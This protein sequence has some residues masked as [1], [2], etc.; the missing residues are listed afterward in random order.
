MY[1]TFSRKIKEIPFL[2]SF[3]GDRVIYKPRN[4]SFNEVK[5]VLGWGEKKN[6]TK[7]KNFA[8]KY[9]LPY[10]SLEDGFI[11]SYGLRIKGY[12]P[13]SLIVDPIGIYYD[14]TKPSLLEHLLNEG[15][16][17]KKDLLEAEKALNLI[18][19]HEISKFNYQEK[20]DPSILKGKRA[21]RVLVIDQT[22]NDLSVLLGMATK[23]SFFEMLD[24][25]LKDNPDADIYIKIHPDVLSGKKKGY[26]TDV[27]EG[28]RIYLITKDVNPISLL[29]FFDKIYTVSS[30]MGFEAL[31]LG[32]P[33]V[34]F[35]IPFYAGWGLTEDI[36][37]IPRRKRKLSLI[38]L[39]YFSY[40]KYCRYINPINGKLGTIFDVIN[41]IL[42]QREMEDRI[43]KFNYYCIDFHIA[44]RKFLTPYLKTSKNRVYFVKAK[45]LKRNSNFLEDLSREK[46]IVVVWGNKGKNNLLKVFK[47]NVPI[48]VIEDGFIRSVGLGS[49]F[50]PPMSIVIDKRGIYYNPQEESDLEYILNNYNFSEAEIEKAKEIRKLII[51]NRITKYNLENLKGHETL[52]KIKEFAKDKKIILVPGQVEDDEAV[53]LGGGE[54]K[55]NLELLKKVRMRDQDSFIIY[56]PH[57][58]ILS[59]NRQKEKW[60]KRLREVCD[61]IEEEADILSCIEIADEIHTLTSLSGF[62]AL[63]RGKRVFT[64]GAPFYAGWG[65]TIDELKF[66]RRKRNLTIEELIAGTLLIYPIYYDWKL[67]A[68]ADCET[69]IY[70]IIEEKQNFKSNLKS[71][72]PIFIKKGI[73]YINF[74]KRSIFL[75][76][77]EK[78]FS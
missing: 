63:I 33:V 72:L 5:G 61:Y 76:V 50:I 18:L 46:A 65:L 7:A 74:L 16:A 58:D 41:F 48:Y 19:E 28:E 24:R 30:Q 17:D 44:R 40:I 8:Q 51:E 6:A 52:K 73:N 62:D 71:N 67:K 3:L 9:N 78:L 10:I 53:L 32:K 69:I 27:K 37:G 38:E 75:F 59:K 4:V 31:L 1:I 45:D 14:A 68:F 64:Y 2:E 55:S 47:E 12:P 66:P 54:I 35:G 25:A 57:P 13:L 60:F 77:K 20:A 26:L 21:K 34:C 29:K 56:K 70:R 39:F 11:C 15:K 49:E 36:K 43:G 22:Y 23:E 42:K